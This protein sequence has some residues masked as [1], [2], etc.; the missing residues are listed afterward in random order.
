MSGNNRTAGTESNA[1]QA[2]DVSH[3]VAERAMEYGQGAAQHYVKEP[4]R[5]LISLAKDYAK[6]HPDVAACWAFAF[7]IVVGW[8]MKP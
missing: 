8:K 2:H 7:G 1:S 5:D 3:R 6:D 4:A